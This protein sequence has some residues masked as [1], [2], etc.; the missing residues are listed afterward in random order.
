MCDYGHA[1]SRLDATS[2]ASR[3]SLPKAAINS[4]VRCPKH[5]AHDNLKTTALPSDMT[6][7]RS[8]PVLGRNRV[9][10]ALASFQYGPSQPP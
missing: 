6:H 7:I 9:V 3:G 5:A 4:G 10:R 8:M 1:R 2:A